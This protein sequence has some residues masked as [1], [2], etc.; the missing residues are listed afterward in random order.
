MSRWARARIVAVAI[1]VGVVVASCGGGGHSMFDAKA[2]E[3]DRIASV[4]W[5]MFGLATAV[6][7]VVAG[8]IIHAATRGRRKRASTSRLNETKFIWIGGVIVPMVILAIL[9]V[10]TVD[11]TSALRNA[12]PHELHI[13]VAGE[14]WW[15]QVRYPGTGV[16]TANEIHVPRGTPIDLHLT[17][18]NVIHSF[19][20]P[21]LAGKMDTIPGQPNDLRFTADTV[22]RYLGRC[23]EFCGL[24]HA[25]MGIEVVVDSPADFGRW[26][27]RRRRVPL[28]PAS[29]E[30][31]AG[32]LVFQR[33]ACAGCH[34]IRGTD[35]S[36][37]V[38]P[39]LTDVGSRARLGADTLLNTPENMRAWIRDAQSFK[40]GIAMPPFR[41]LSTRD[42]DALASYLESL[43]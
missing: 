4:W 9:A 21:Q 32:Q 25:H 39:D 11:T 15:W 24:Q 43:R 17:S 1:A 26:L 6:Y 31:A 40:S 30:A 33:E 5:L 22:G 27:A 37:T 19:W 23:A 34:T 29:E 14:L 8:F 2:S 3:A 18:D 20:V 7:V 10:V 12:S 38:G 41:S 42:V 13:D 28:E 36:G 16:V 35:A